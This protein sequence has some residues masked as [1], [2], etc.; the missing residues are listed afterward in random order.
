MVLA[1]SNHEQIKVLIIED[2][3]KIAELN[4]TYTEKVPGFQVVSIARN[5]EEAVGKVDLH[6]PDLILLDIFFPDMI[7]LNFLKWIRSQTTNIDVI[8]ITAAKE[9][10]Y[11]KHAIHGGIFDYIVKPFRFERFKETLERYQNY[12][13]QLHKLTQDSLSVEQREIDRLI[14]KELKP[15][16]QSE[17][18]KGID[19]LTLEK[20]LQVVSLQKKGMT[21]EEVARQ[22]GASRSTARRYLEYLVSVSKLNTDLVY[23][24]V[25]RPER[26][27]QFA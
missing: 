26:V 3:S 15:Q 4:K 19:P 18:P 21:A 10:E 9:I 7:G 20:V 12:Y 8:M 27:Y 1:H 16:S 2:D 24:S 25:G 23:G 11:I 13:L 22:V 5:R 14:G 17:L 6:Q